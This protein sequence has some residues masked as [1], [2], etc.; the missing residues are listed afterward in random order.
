MRDLSVFYGSTPVSTI[1]P[2]SIADH[3]TPALIRVGDPLRN[4]A[5]CGSCHGGIDRKT[6]SPRLDGAPAPYLQAQLRAFALGVRHNDINGQMRNVA[7][8]MTAA[9][10]ESASLYYASRPTLPPAQGAA[11][12]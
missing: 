6:G 5:P 12:E 9:E 10:M 2:A 1:S 11:L 7:R 3:A 4:I 8:A